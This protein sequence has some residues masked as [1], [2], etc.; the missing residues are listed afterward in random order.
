MGQ[1]FA[2]LHSY[3][4]ALMLLSGALV[5]ACLLMA[6]LGPYTYQAVSRQAPARGGAAP[7]A[8]KQ[9]SMAT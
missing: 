5:I 9:P 8:D 1:S 2:K 4:P 7:E 3:Q 6:R